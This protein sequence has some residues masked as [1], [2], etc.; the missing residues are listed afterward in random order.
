MVL[1]CHV[2]LPGGVL[3]GL[4]PYGALGVHVFFAISGFLITY[5]L[6]EEARK[7]GFID[8]RRFYIRRAF[9]ILPAAFLYLSAVA[10]LGLAAGLIPMDWRQLSA[11]AFFYRNYYTGD[12]TLT[13][14]TG[15]YW[16]LS[17]EEHFYLLWPGLLA[18]AGI[19][20]G[21]WLAPALACSVAAWRG[22]DTSFHWVGT[23]HPSW[24]DLVSR[25]DYRL[26]GLLW[27]CAAAFLWNAEPTRTWIRRVTSPAWI[28]AILAVFAGLVWW[29][30]PGS[31]ALLAI[32]LPGLILYTVARPERALGRLLETR[33][34]AWFGRVSY[35]VYLWQMLFLP[36][37]GIPISMAR[38]QWFPLNV[39]FVVAAASA[40]YY[41]VEQ[42]CRRLGRTLASNLHRPRTAPSM[43]AASIT[44]SR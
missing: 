23:A 16:S 3:S 18:I 22:L 21:R 34:V 40:S 28:I 27:G 24:M 36:A 15:H 37:Y 33:P 8:L 31:E 6:L 9:R 35:S 38:V 32:L 41:V 30:G 43:A 13:W 14:Y 19:A 10:I 26:D 11:A 4:A 17:V 44:G 7:D 1:F 12:A 2:R 20:R 39:V 25:T 42:P 5:R 29:Q